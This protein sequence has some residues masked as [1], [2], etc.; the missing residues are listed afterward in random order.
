MSEYL[1]VLIVFV[2]AGLF[3]LGFLVISALLG[4]NKPL[5]S[6]LSVYECGLNPVG[7]A[8]E[9]FSVKFYLVALLFILFDVEVVF[10]YPWAINFKEAIAK[11]DGLYYL[12]IMGEFFLLL[13]LGLVFAW[14]K[15]AL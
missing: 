10:L 6:K 15:G 4:P 2:V 9:R 11:G 8:R 5:K 12:A 3:S 14:R 1:P 13:A 7:T